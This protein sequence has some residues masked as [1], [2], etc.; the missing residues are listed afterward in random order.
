M[1]R[2]AKPPPHPPDEADAIGL[3]VDDYVIKS[4]IGAGGM[5][6]VYEALH[7]V[8]GK[9]VAIKVLRPDV[10]HD[11]TTAAQ[12]L[13]EARAVNAIGH[14]GVVDIYNI[15]TLPDG[16]QY[17][18]ME[19]LA[20]APLD[21]YARSALPAPEV[22]QILDEVLDALAAVHTVGLVH[23]DLKP[24][25]IFRVT[26]QSGA[27]YLKLLDFGLTRPAAGAGAEKRLIGTPPYMAPEQLRGEAATAQSDLFALGVVAYE[28]LAGKPPF[29]G[30]PEQIARDQALGADRA[31]LSQ[32]HPK[33]VEAVLSLL[34]ADP[35]ER[36]ASAAEI[37]DALRAL[38][39]SL[40]LRGAA[41]PAR[42][43]ALP[44]PALLG[45]LMGAVRGWFSSGKLEAPVVAPRPGPLPRPP[46]PA[47]EISLEDFEVVSAEEGA[48]LEEETLQRILEA[49][50][51]HLRGLKNLPTFPAAAMRMVEFVN[52]K[53]PEP[54]ELVR[55]IS[56]DPALTAQVMR[57]ANS[58]YS[59]RGVEIK[60]VKDAV[61]RLG[62]R[63]VAAVATAAATMTL[64]NREMRQRNKVFVDEQRIIWVES[65]SSAFGSAWLSMEH[66]LGDSDRAFMGGMLH[67]IGKT[68]AVNALGDPALLKKLDGFD[69][70]LMLPALLEAMHVEVGARMV[71]EWKLP[72]YLVQICREHHEPQE[73][74][75]QVKELHVVRVVSAAAEMRV[76]PRWAATRLD[77]VQQSAEILG[78]DRHQ[79]RAASTQVRDFVAKA[80]ALITSAGRG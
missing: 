13:T 36:P 4:R 68:L 45:R 19:L 56:Q 15:G 39:A 1:D 42:A 7:P 6:V 50:L 49:T 54:V 61:V 33:I 57:M 59:S 18:V 25:N 76:A 21:R 79:L 62:Y 26:P 32:L 16:R 64:F 78:L 72:A 10:A 48:P 80:E 67:D 63:E 35:K 31:A 9:R 47:L 22:L 43:D 40:G 60:T 24:S 12:L 8:I 5:G 52:R 2:I 77:E 30:T 70:T 44:Q 20:G 29:R 37:R 71:E 51:T 55:I 53:D 34:A 11:P 17:L 75:R 14:R 65:L 73:G 23:R 46:R 38:C 74:S 27:P 69:P 58:A 28:L 41:P 66:R 3:E